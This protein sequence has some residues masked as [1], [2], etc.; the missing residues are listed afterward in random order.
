LKNIPN[1]MYERDQ[2][3]KIELAQ[4]KSLFSIINYQ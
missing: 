2:T 4:G 1:G 3:W